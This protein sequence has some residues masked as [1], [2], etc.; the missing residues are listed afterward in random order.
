MDVNLIRFVLNLCSDVIFKGI[1]TVIVSKFENSDISFS[2]F[3]FYI[4]GFY[5][6]FVIGILARDSLFLD[7]VRIKKCCICNFS[8]N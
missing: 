7:M 2:I 8:I 4:C 1:Y 3:V 6:I 5:F